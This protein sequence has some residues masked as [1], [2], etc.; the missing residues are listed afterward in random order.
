MKR[1]GAQVDVVR[2]ILDPP[3]PGAWNMA[4]DEALL[5]SAA[6]ARR[7][8]LRFYGWS[9]PTVSL[10][11]FQRNQSRQEHPPSLGCAVVR[12]STGGGAIV[13]DRE[14]TYSFTAPMADRFSDEAGRLYRTFHDTL[15]E[16]LVE[17][18]LPA[19][20]N[21]APSARSAASEPFLCFLRRTQGDLL[22]G[23]HK[24]AGSAQRRHKRGVLQH[25]S[26]LLRASPC[27][28]EL[29]GLNDLSP[30]TIANNELIDAWT[31]RL[32]RALHV[33]VDREEV[34]PSESTRATE[35]HDRRFGTTEWTARR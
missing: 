13:H 20:V 23:P 1:S 22:V 8:T 7:A 12:R 31:S 27:A 35:V 10:G 16:L 2:L 25:G 5:E 15:A 17:M 19:E 29:P 11:Y 26:V 21:G 28:P 3:A 9:E 14:L 18:G 33:R 32:G 6:T 4:V 34:S 30:Q 24:V